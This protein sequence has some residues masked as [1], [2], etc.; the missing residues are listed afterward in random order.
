MATDQPNNLFLFGGGLV[1]HA[2]QKSGKGDSAAEK[3]QEPNDGKGGAR[4]AEDKATA[5]SDQ[6]LAARHS[7]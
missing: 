2:Q 7:K 5:G 6:K 3:K 4:G 1:R